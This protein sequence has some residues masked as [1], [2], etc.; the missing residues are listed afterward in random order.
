MNLLNTIAKVVISVIVSL[1]LAQLQ[2]CAA[3]AVSGAATGVA[4]ATDRRT[5]GTIVE[6]QSIEMKVAHSI[7]QDQELW[8][9]SHINPVSY[10]NVLLLVGQVP[11][12]DFKRRA[13]QALCDIPKVRRVHNEIA[14]GE[15]ASLATRSND[16][17]IT[18]QI[19]TKMMGTKGFNFTRVKVVTENGVVYLMGLTTPEEELTATEIS[20]AVK[21]VDKVIQIFEHIETS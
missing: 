14:I 16:S 2:G 19:K 8:K 12:E 7:A 20:R 3:A 4:M 5:A 10:N 18:A 13:E 9:K 6:D 21:G 17:W 1:S 15:P 11:N